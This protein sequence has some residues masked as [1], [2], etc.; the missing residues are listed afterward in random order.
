M[1]QTKRERIIAALGTIGYTEV[2]SNS[3]KYRC[4]QS[5]RAGHTYFVG[6]NGAVRAGKTI[7]DSVS[8]THIVERFLVEQER[9]QSSPNPRTPRAGKGS[10]GGISAGAGPNAAPNNPQPMEGE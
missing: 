6:K 7:S 3:R 4:L 9:K 1:K 2:P 10:E 8:M 5:R